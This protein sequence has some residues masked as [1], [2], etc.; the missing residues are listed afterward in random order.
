MPEIIEVDP[1]DQCPWMGSQIS[2]LCA[3]FCQN[4]TN[5]LIQ[6]CAWPGG[7]SAHA[8]LASSGYDPS[9]ALLLALQFK[10]YP[11]AAL[12]AEVLGVATAGP[13]GFRTATT[14]TS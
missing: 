13:A 7:P 3:V 1:G 6:I 8:D 11:G 2:L 4:Q 12:G 9:L 10:Q 5:K 14:A